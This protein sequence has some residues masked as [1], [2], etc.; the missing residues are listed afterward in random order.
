LVFV[1]CFIGFA[2]ALAEQLMKVIAEQLVE[3]LA[4]VS[5]SA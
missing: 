2:E 4:K 5:G 3:V 1:I